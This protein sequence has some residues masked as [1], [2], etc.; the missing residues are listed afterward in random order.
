MQLKHLVALALTAS[1]LA[2]GTPPAAADHG[3]CGSAHEF[4]YDVPP[5]QA[6]TG[7]TDWFD[8]KDFWYDHSDLTGESLRLIVL[9]PVTGDSDLYVWTEDCT[10]LICASTAG[11]TSTD[12]C[13][14][15]VSTPTYVEVRN[16]DG[17]SSQY[18]VTVTYSPFF[19]Q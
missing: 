10:R 7:T 5:V 11:G 13:L 6:S 4:Q 3:T 8:T 14:V 16:W 12:Q 9:Q 1:G 18:G 19:F 17:A 15:N 2:G